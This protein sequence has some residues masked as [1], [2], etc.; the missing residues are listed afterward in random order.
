MELMKIDKNSITYWFSLF[1]KVCSNVFEQRNKLGTGKNKIIEIDESLIRGKRKYNKGRYLNMDIWRQNPDASYFC[2]EESEENN[3]EN[4]VVFADEIFIDK[5]KNRIDGP[6]V[7]G[8]VE[9]EVDELGKRKAVEARYFYV[10]KRDKNTLLPII[11][12]EVEKGST[13]YSDEWAAYR[14]LE[15]YGYIHKTVNHSQSYVAP[16]GSHTNTVEVSWHHMKT[17]FLRQMFGVSEKLLVSYLHEESVRS[18]FKNNMYFFN[19]FLDFLS[20]YNN[21]N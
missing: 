12:K 20:L 2:P 7:F 14:T 4:E 3:S 11:L 8:I 15:N 10:E 19:K 16:D 9:C 21:V 1:R 5:Y 6:W 17:R 18:K 13:I